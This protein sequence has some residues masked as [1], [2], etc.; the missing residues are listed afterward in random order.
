MMEIYNFFLLR[1]VFKN[2]FKKTW[3]GSK[4]NMQVS[5]LV[6]RTL[7]RHERLQTIQSIYLENLR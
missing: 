7:V 6:F 2:S 5:A 4:I 3:V 1:T